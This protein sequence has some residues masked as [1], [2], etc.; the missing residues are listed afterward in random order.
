MKKLSTQGEA[1]VLAAIRTAE[2]STSAEICVHVDARG[3]SD[4]MAEAQRVFVR[5]G[6]TSTRDR[7]AVLVYLS[8][9]ERKFAFWGDTGAN[10]AIGEDGW[11]ALRELFAAR[12]AAAAPEE[13]IA[14]VV[15]WLGERLAVPYPRRPDDVNE[16]PDSLQSGD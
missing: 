10:V 11:Q 6:M 5:S 7:N 15:R 12:L 16:L 9:A 4:P 3:A 14:D 13:A 2:E 1:L 8:L